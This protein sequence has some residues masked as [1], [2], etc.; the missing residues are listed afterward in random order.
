MKKNILWIAAFALMASCGANV[1]YEKASSFKNEEGKEGSSKKEK[2][3]DSSKLL[4]QKKRPTVFDLLKYARSELVQLVAN[5]DQTW[6]PRQ[7]HLFEMYRAGIARILENYPDHKVVFFGRDSEFMYDAFQTILARHPEGYKLRN[8]VIL[9]PISRNV[10]GYPPNSGQGVAGVGET[11]LNKYLDA[12]DIHP[13]RILSGE[14]KVLFVDSWGRGT[15]M[16]MILNAM[17]QNSTVDDMIRVLQNAPLKLLFSDNQ[18]DTLHTVIEY[19]KT[20]VEMV[21]KKGYSFLD[22]VTGHSVLSFSDLLGENWGDFNLDR[23]FLI[24]ENQRLMLKDY[25]HWY[26]TIREL[27]EDGSHVTKYDP[28]QGG[29]GKHVNVNFSQPDIELE[30]KMLCLATQLAVMEAF[31]RAEISTQFN[32]LIYKAAKFR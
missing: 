14:E 18:Q 17:T 26:G 12:H 2:T 1:P 6:V 10:T 29:N 31:S 9:L 21:G 30:N 22:I 8:D 15:Q 23:N 13:D 7:Q 28:N 4:G 27:S 19:F 3:K 25:G 16:L 11:R 5:I 24:D 20:Q 32:D